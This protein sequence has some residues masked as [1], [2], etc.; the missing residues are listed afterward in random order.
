MPRAGWCRECGEWVWVDGEDACQYGHGPECLED[1]HEQAE[2]V[3]R[4]RPFGVGEFPRELSRFNWGAFLLPIAWGVVYGAW[5]VVA[6]W[7]AAA[8]LPLVIAMM[9]GEAAVLLQNVILVTVVAEIASGL[10]RLWSGVN[11]NRVLWKRDAMRLE[12]SEK[13]KPRFT[14][15]RFRT[16]QRQW[17]I[18]SAALV[19]VTSA[20]SIP[21]AASVWADYELTYVGAVMP[22]LWLG[23][24]VLLGVWLDTRMRSE[25]PD[26]E[27]A[28]SIRA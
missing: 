7:A 2:Q 19:G 1:V 24:E 18:W 5:P 8:L 11:A 3:H 10:A 27:R 17:V 26:G 22:I 28:A 20:A 6:V 4:D 16:R 21:L 9:L 13:A 14:M 12:V 15:E 25:P 23:A